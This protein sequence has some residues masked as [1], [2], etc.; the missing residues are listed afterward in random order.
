MDDNKRKQL[1]QAI[2]QIEKQFGK[3]SI[4]KLGDEVQK[5]IDVISTG[6]MTLD[7][8]LGIGGVP[9]G[10]IIEIYGPESSGKTTLTLHIL[11]EAQKMGGTAA[12]ID[13]EHALDPV[14]AARLGV[15]TNNLLISQPDTG[16]QALEICEALV[17]S[18][19]VDCVII[20]SV[21][22]LTPKAE[23]DGEMGDSFMGVQARL[24]SQAL[25]KLTAII[26]KSNACVIFI[27][28][29]RD[30]IGVMYGNPETTTG[31][32]ALKFYSSIRMDIRKTDVIKDG[33]EIIG[34]RTKVKIVK[35]KLAPPFKTA[36]FDIM[37]GTGINNEGCV[38]DMAIELDVVQKSGSW[39]SYKG[40]KIG[41]G[42]ENVKNFLQANPEVYEEVKN[43]INEKLR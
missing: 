19:A 25:R 40:E 12:F 24:M 18:G 5:S 4:M 31:G 17:R 39:Y 32:K 27:N 26:N 14:Y 28:Q 7:H 9:K 42:K 35:N 29:L 15:D 2:L 6:C 13:A 38:I 43:K 37:Y 21:A 36:E 23:I 41:Q 11:A 1:E 8:A 16:E 22:A 20:D 30:K 33:S 3:G 10:R 34:N